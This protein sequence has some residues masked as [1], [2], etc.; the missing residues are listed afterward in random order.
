MRKPH[1]HTLR[2]RPSWFRPVAVRARNDGWSEVRQCAFLAQLYFTGSVSAAA[3]AVGMS[4]ASAY[5][6]RARPGAEGFAFAW[7][8]VLTLPGAGHPGAAREDGR[9]VTMAT[10]H[11]RLETDLVR[12]V[13]HSGRMTAVDRKPDNSTLFRLLRLTKDWPEPPDDSDF[14]RASGVIEKQPR[15]L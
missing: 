7:D 2:R 9:K 13:I 15:S 14:W 4:R 5:R 6:L 1:T 11:A 12:P 3:K 8:R 10:L